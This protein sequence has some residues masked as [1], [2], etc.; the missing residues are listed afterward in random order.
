MSVDDTRLKRETQE[1]NKLRDATIPIQKVEV[2]PRPQAEKMCNRCHQNLMEAKE[3]LKDQASYHA[4]DWYW[5]CPNLQCMNK[6]LMPTTP[7]G[8]KKGYRTKSTVV[9]KNPILFGTY[10][11]INQSWDGTNRRKKGDITD[12]DLR[13]LSA[14]T[15]GYLPSAVELIDSRDDTKG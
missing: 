2:S 10:D 8:T 7:E 13:D 6:E 15:G 3:Q 9:S 11:R 12:E 14:L 4:G 1:R 5:V